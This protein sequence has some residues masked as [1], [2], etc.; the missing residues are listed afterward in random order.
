[1]AMDLTEIGQAKVEAL[2]AIADAVSRVDKRLEEIEQR[3]EG[4]EERLVER[5]TDN[6]FNLVQTLKGMGGKPQ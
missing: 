6:D 5:L 2:R 1:M 4:F 3:L